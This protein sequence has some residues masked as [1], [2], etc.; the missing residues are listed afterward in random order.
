MNSRKT[1]RR[2]ILAS[3]VC[4]IFIAL[5]FLSA[6]FIIYE[7]DH[8]CTGDNC[9]ICACIQSAGQTLKLLGSAAAAS[10][11]FSAGAFLTL[12]VLSLSLSVLTSSTPVSQKIRMNN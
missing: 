12:V 8:D 10:Q 4:L 3:A 9:P 7:A 2:R 6:A 11:L 1:Q 5:I